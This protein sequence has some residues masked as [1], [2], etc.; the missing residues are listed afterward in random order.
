[1][2]LAILASGALAAAAPPASLKITVPAT[3]H[4][5]KRYSIKV[6]GSYQ[7]SDP[8]GTGYLVAYLQYG[9]AACKPT[10]QA[11]R[12]LPARAWSLD[13]AGKEPHSPFTRIDNWTAGTLTG[14]RRVCAYLYPKVVS[15][16]TRVHPIATASA[17]FRNK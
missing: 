4:P 12:T 14:P 17:A 9:A 5:H 1:L 7:L 3:V 10:A 2:V 16:T 8:H 13:Y 11:E 6:A 15:N